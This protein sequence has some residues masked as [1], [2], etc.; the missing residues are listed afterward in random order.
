MPLGEVVSLG[1]AHTFHLIKVEV[2]KDQAKK[3]KAKR[4]E[5]GAI[6]YAGLSRSPL[7][8]VCE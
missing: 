4:G 5:E 2:G 1:Y 7:R 3:W 8:A 6:G